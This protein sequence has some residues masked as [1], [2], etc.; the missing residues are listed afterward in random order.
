[1]PSVRASN[2]PSSARLLVRM[3]GVVASRRRA[4]RHAVTRQADASSTTLVNEGPIRTP[5]TQ[6]GRADRMIRRFGRS[7]SAPTG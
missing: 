4:C 5:L 3:N 6:G 1:M 7:T 2:T